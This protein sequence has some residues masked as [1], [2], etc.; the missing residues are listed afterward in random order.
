MECDAGKTLIVMLNGD[1]KMIIDHVLQYG[2]VDNLRLW[3][4]TTNTGEMHIN[5]D[6][7]LAIGFYDEFDEHVSVRR[8]L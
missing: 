7:V 1:A 4:V 5:M 8:Y 2:T 6:K 3:K